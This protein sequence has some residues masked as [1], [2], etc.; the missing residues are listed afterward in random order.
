MT[1]IDNDGLAEE[2][3]AAF[4][5]TAASWH[6]ENYTY[7]SLLMFYLAAIHFFEHKPIGDEQ[8]QIK[9]MCFL[10]EKLAEASEKLL[11]PLVNKLK[12]VVDAYA[13]EQ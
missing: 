6:V 13:L 5:Q 3:C 2:I 4:E 10:D 9:V 11:A 1:A 7:A 8:V 12:V